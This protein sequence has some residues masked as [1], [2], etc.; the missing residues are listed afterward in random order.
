MPP[1]HVMQLIVKKAFARSC[2][3]IFLDTLP[4]YLWRVDNQLVLWRKH[5]KHAYLLYLANTQL[6]MC[7]LCCHAALFSTFYPPKAGV[8]GWYSHAFIAQQHVDSGSKGCFL[9]A[10]LV[11]FVWNVAFSYP[12]ISHLHPPSL[13]FFLRLKVFK[14]HFYGIIR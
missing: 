12:V 10:K 8:D 5:A 1:T 9:R 3:W 6:F 11:A 2:E 4:L 7:F 13:L 14:C